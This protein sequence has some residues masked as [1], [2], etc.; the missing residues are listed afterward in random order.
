M[1][2]QPPKKI[3]DA[4]QA[5]S[6]RDKYRSHGSVID[7]KEATALGLSVE[8]LPPENDLWQRLW[9]LYSMYDFDVRQN[10]YLKVFEGRASSTSIA[11]PPKAP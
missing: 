9:L 10:D 11:A 1:K 3:E 4:I 7:F 5:L 8:Y 6:S 2:G